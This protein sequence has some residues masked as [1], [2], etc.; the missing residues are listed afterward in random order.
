[1]YYHLE[2]AADLGGLLV[3]VWALG[4]VRYLQRPPVRY[5]W[6]LGQS[7]EEHMRV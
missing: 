4:S 3:E 6:L 5:Q 1:M 2:L 7:R